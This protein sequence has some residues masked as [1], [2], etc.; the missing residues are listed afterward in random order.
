[1]GFVNEY[2]PAGDVEKYGLDEIDR[3]FVVGGTGARDPTHPPTFSG[4]A[5]R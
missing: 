4:A 2:I 3:R 5:R 1:M